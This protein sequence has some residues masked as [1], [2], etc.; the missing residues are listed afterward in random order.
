[1]G[2]IHTLASRY[3][4]HAVAPVHPCQIIPAKTE[5]RMNRFYFWE[6]SNRI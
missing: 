2:P 1:M 5:L 6:H 3:Q 4:Q